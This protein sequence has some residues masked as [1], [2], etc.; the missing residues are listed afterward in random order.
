[1]INPKNFRPGFQVQIT[2]Y[3]KKLAKAEEQDFSKKAKYD[4]T[5]NIRNAWEITLAEFADLAVTV[6][7]A[8]RP[9]P[10]PGA[11]MSKKV[12]VTIENKGTMEAKDFDIQLVLSSDLVIPVKP[13]VYSENFKE[14]VL[15]KDAL[16]KVASV[17]AGETVTI[18]LEGAVKIPDDTPVGRYYLGAV[19]D[20]ANMIEELDEKNNFNAKFLM[21]TIP[22]PKRLVVGIPDM[23]LAYDP[24]NFG[25]QIQCKGVPI[26][27]GNDW[28]K[29]RIKPHLHQLKHTSW[30]GFHWEIDTA[31]RTVWKVKG[32]KFCKRGGVG[33]EIKNIKVEVKGG[34]KTTPP[35]H[36]IL[37]LSDTRFEYEPPTG[38]FK[39]ITHGAQVAHLPSWNAAKLESHLYQFRFKVWQDSFWEVNAAKKQVVKVTGGSF[40]Q[41]GGTAAP[42]DFN[43][44]IE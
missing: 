36:V 9:A 14:D 4:Q 40:G 24:V 10:M 28:R 38:K 18:T 43:V 5:A 11:E 42:L 15:L 2:E 21:I 17:K 27:I 23:V 1:K 22:E 32:A 7:H 20:P 35:S 41:I 26:S 25:L 16:Q 34:S 12:S 19:A 37:R 31:D 3:K 6:T 29:C 8:I 39:I 44:K 13:A 33:E 30:K